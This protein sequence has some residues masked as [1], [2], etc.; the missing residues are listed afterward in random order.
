MDTHRARRLTQ[1]TRG[2]VAIMALTLILAA[3]TNSAASPSPS[4]SGVASC[5]KSDLALK[6]AGTL[7]LST[8]NPAYSPWFQGGN[9][10]SELFDGDYG[11]DPYK[12]G[13]AHV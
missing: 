9:E 4:P 11:N 2:F 5:A 3:C 13:R 7:T 1:T 8:D 6:T 12:I 10:G